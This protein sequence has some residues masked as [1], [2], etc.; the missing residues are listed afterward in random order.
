MEFPFQMKPLLLASI[1]FSASVVSANAQGAPAPAPAKAATPAKASGSSAAASSGYRLPPGI[2]RGRGLI[3]TAFT[4]RY[5]DL[6]IGT[7]AAAEPNKLYKVLYTGWLASDGHEFDS[8]EDHRPPLRDKDGKVVMGDDG[9][10]KLGDVQPISFMQGFGRVIPGF[11]QGF[12]GMKVGGKRRLFIPWQLAYGA[13]GRP[14]YDAAHTGIPPKADL[15]FDIELVDV[16]EMPT[17]PNRPMPNPVRPGASLPGMHL[18]PGAGTMPGQPGGAAKPT[19]PAGQ[20]GTT[21]QPAPQAPQSST[22]SG[23]TPAGSSTQ[24]E[25]KPAT[26][27]P[28]EQPAQQP[29]AQSQPQ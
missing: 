14:G 21:A 7:G 27:P 16:G 5:Q 4:L 9:K 24:P 19:T 23:S 8:S 13:R 12:D 17:P 1:F 3:K 28:A 26:P 22:P 29:Q 6:K 2:P 15:I 20:P 11:D 25:T 18:P 10:P